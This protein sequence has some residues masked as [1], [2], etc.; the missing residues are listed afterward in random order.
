MFEI[1]YT[2]VQ[3]LML[4]WRFAPTLVKGQKGNFS[5]VTCQEEGG[6]VEV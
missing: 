3:K 4:N 2:S 1:V 6:R 5:S